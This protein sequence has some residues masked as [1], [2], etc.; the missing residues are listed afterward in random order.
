MSTRNAVYRLEKELAFWQR[1]HEHEPMDE[2]EFKLERQIRQLANP[3]EF[4]TPR[5]NGHIEDDED[6]DG[7][8]YIPRVIGCRYCGKIGLQ[9]KK[10]DGKWRL[11]ESGVL[12]T[13]DAYRKRREQS[14]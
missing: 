2:R 14:R 3:D 11:A 13:C 5:Y 8:E 12:H 10:V 4:G 9:W 6:E 1:V 7:Y